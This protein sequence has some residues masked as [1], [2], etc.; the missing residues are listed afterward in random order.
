MLTVDGA[1]FF[2]VN[3]SVRIWLE[4][5]LNAACPADPAQLPLTLRL[6]SNDIDPDC[7]TVLD[8]L[9][10]SAFDGYGGIPLTD[11]TDCDTFLQGPQEQPD[12]TWAIF[13]DQ[14]EWEMSGSTSPETVFGAYITG[15]ADD[16]L[17]AIKRFAVPATM[18][19]DGPPADTLKVSG[20][21]Q[22]SCN[23]PLPED[24]PA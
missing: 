8:D 14:Q 7:N 17:V 3:E 24:L 1:P 13:L 22:P 16:G 15:G 20:I 4:Y 12:G 19:T 5:L 23:Y 6:F 10:E 21:I 9:V 2:L 18:G 11:G